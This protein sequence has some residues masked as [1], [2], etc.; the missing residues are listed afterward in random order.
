MLMTARKIIT[1]KRIVICALVFLI[2]GVFVSSLAEF[3]DHLKKEATIQVATFSKDG[4]TLD[5]SAAVGPFTAG[6]N[7]KLT[8]MENNAYNE[9]VDSSI[10]LRAKWTSP[11]N[12]CR[13]F[14]NLSTSDNMVC[15][16]DGK[17]VPYTINDDATISIELPTITLEANQ[18]GV[19]R[20]I[21]LQIPQTLAGTG[22]LSFDFEN[23]T[24]SQ[25]PYGFVNEYSKDELNAVES[26]S[27]TSDIVWAIGAKNAKDLTAK[28][29]GV[30]EG[31]YS[32]S[33]EG[34]GE[35]K[36]FV[37]KKP[38]D[39]S[40]SWTS[41][42][43][44]FAYRSH[45]TALDLSTGITS[46]GEAAFLG[47]D[48]LPDVEFPSGIEHIGAQAL[49]G[50]S[51]L[52]NITFLHDKNDEIS[53]PP[54]GHESGAFYVAS[55]VETSVCSDNPTVSEY[56]WISDHRKVSLVRIPEEIHIVTPPDKSDYV[57]GEDFD[58]TGMV[59]AVT[60][61]DGLTE[62][63]TGYTIP[64]GKGLALDRTDITVEYEENGIRLK[65]TVS[66]TVVPPTPV[67]AAKDSWYRGKA[68]K[69]TITKIKIVDSYQKTGDELEFWDASYEQNGSVMAYLADAT[70]ILAGNGTGTI[71]ANADSELAFSGFT[72]ASSIT[73][74]DVLDTHNVT[75]MTGFFKNCSSL[76]KADVSSL[77]TAKVQEMDHLFEDCAS[78]ESI[79]LSTWDI[80]EVTTTSHMFS[81]CS[82]LTDVSLPETM[83]SQRS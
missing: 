65:T 74:F 9:P 70:L 5:R 14:H 47:F 4:Y 57:E 44:W 2:L 82:A 67:L 49:A 79:D 59:V 68:E 61:K 39:D 41:S 19:E 15:S 73:G 11:D 72:K 56:D 69:S 58:D 30:A 27:F 52:T 29:K 23:V 31:E 75:D 60:Y 13:M 55:V 77:N 80:G 34:T 81:K 17:I 10:T 83:V 53:L 45:I 28:L 54:A 24:I 71:V 42:A 48:N 22:K 62:K 46:I 66:I 18:T 38:S 43:P 76:T 16:A 6:E 21:N 63:V 64:D 12:N 20:I 40:A 50:T 35:M 3:S 33:L 78:L 32:L 1:N 51:S 8:L 36:D 7:I 26:L 25:S 37:A